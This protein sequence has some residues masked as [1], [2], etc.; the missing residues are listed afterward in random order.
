MS[1]QKLILMYLPPC[2][3]IGCLSGAGECDGVSTCTITLLWNDQ[4]LFGV[5]L[6]VCLD[7]TGT[8]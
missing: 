1:L 2:G 6:T 5:L 7:I 3:S 8:R 4:K